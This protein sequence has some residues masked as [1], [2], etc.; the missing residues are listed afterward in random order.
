MSPRPNSIHRRPR[1]DSGAARLFAWARA[2]RGA[3]TAA[4]AGDESEISADRAKAIVRALVTAGY[5][6]IADASRSLGGALGA[7]P[8]TYRLTPEGRSLAGPPTLIVDG[9]SGNIVGVRAPGDGSG[10][11]LLRARIEASGLSTTAAAKALGLNPRTLRRI[12]SGETPISADD[13]A[14]A[15]AGRSL[16]CALDRGGRAARRQ[17]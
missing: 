17:G 8:A 10:N 1:S 3:W 14:L 11:A 7:T 15:H 13:P 12:L 4:E 6:E 9:A 5:A 16:P 2:R